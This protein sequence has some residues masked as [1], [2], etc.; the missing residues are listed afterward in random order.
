MKYYISKLYL[1]ILFTSV[2]LHGQEDFNE[3]Y[4]EQEIYAINEIL[5]NPKKTDSI[6]NLVHMNSNAVKVYDE[7]MKSLD[8]DLFQNKKVFINALTIGTGYSLVDQVIQQIDGTM[9]SQ[10][11][12]RLSLTFGISPKTLFFQKSDRRKLES[13]KQL[14]FEQQQALE[15]DLKQKVL[16]NLY[17]QLLALESIKVKFSL[18]EEKEETLKLMKIKFRN[19]SIS[20]PELQQVETNY[21]ELKITFFQQKFNYLKLKSRFQIML[22]N[23]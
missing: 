17:D 14:A 19:G 4:F 1:I 5:L 21:E 9:E 16:S 15:N 8:E 7:Q 2:A 20:Y 13:S 22:G 12:P 3:V 10:F 23:K 6:I 11:I 18:V